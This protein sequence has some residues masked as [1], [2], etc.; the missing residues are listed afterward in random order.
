MKTT[1]IY[2]NNFE[3]HKR[4]EMFSKFDS[5]DFLNE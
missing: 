4:N 3:N 5:F 1:E 2:N